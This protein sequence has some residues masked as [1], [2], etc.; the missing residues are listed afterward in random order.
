MINDPKETKS[1][2]I[3]GVNLIANTV[4]VT[5]GTKGRLVMYTNYRDFSDP[6][7]YPV[8][9]KDGVTVARNVK[10]NDNTEQQ[11]IK[12]VR[13][14]AKNTVSSSGD[15]PQ[16]L[17]SKIL[18]PSGFITMGDI[19]VG[20]MVCGTNGSIQKVLGIYPKGK[21]RICKVIFEGGSV[22]EC[23]EDHLWQVN[24]EEGLQKVVTTKDIIDSGLYYY[25][26]SGTKKY[27]FSIP[28]T[29]VE[30]NSSK[31]HIDPY[32][33][34]V[35]LGSNKSFSSGL[36]ELFIPKNKIGIL[37]NIPNNYSFVINNVDEDNYT[38]LLE[39]S[40]I[41]DHLDNLGIYSSD[42]SVSFIPEIYKYND[43]N[44]RSSLMRGLYHISNN[45]ALEGFIEYNTGSYMLREDIVEI[46]HSL[47]KTFISSVSVN[48]NSMSYTIVESNTED[49]NHIVSIEVTEDVTE[50]QCIKVSNKDHLYITDNYILTH[51]TTS[52]ILLTQALVN[53]GYRL[54]SEGNVSS[55]EM[56]KEI[57]EAVEDITDYILS[58]SKDISNNLDML[59]ELATISANDEEIGDM[60]YDIINELSVH[61]DIE[62]KKSKRMFTEIE[63]VN[64]MKLHK[65]YFDGFMCN[66]YKNMTF[67]A[68]DANILIYDG[69]IKDYNQI[70][71][72]VKASINEEGNPIP[73]VIYAQDVNRIAINRIEGM[74]K[75]N[76]RPFM[77]VEHDGFGDRRTDI[78]NDLAVVTGGIIVNEDSNTNALMVK[79]SLGKCKEVFVTDRHSSFIGGY[80]NPNNIKESIDEINQ[81]LESLDPTNKQDIK[82]Y[83]KRLA[84]LA[85]GIA[86]IHVGGSTPFEMEE[87]YMRI[88]DAVL[89]V[90]SAISSGISIGG[91]VTWINA[92]VHGI[93]KSRKYNRVDNPSYFMVFD[94][95]QEIPAQLLKNSGE[96]TSDF[97]KDLKK[98]YLSKN[99]KGYNL[100]DRKFY[101]MNDYKVYDATSVLTDVLSNAS[102]VSKSLLSVEVA[103]HFDNNTQGVL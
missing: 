97:F 22:V 41:L 7:G 27:K 91:G 8:L 12:I 57:D 96:Y 4:K 31:V 90:K 32:L 36:L 68:S 53:S 54:L 61:C 3:S 50:M 67:S 93:D 89:A 30:F 49:T 33:L 35:I 6:E 86:V 10:S 77:I 99:K 51:N 42:S 80:G 38:V 69:V 70:A 18:T 37:N 65:G 81:V 73:I 55:W 103:I 43:S 98:K 1:K 75:Y 71:P 29:I 26:L 44:V 101:D 84:N 23:C 45:N 95:L 59:R 34:G 17:Y 74:L 62:V 102:S 83:K 72:Y 87:K 88:D 52:T 14:A 39:D 15:G 64:G 40:K 28:R 76:P 24:T 46:L 47:N 5:L 100:S 48:N 66:D 92:S 20:D 58:E 25:D 11:A 60:I 79:S 82:F 2:I 9:T 13:E 16:P 94:S 85:G 19:K 56:N 63:A 78:M 21:K